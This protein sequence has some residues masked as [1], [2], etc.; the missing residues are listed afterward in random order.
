MLAS[1]VTLMNRETI[2]DF[3]PT[4]H[5]IDTSKG[6]VMLE[7]GASWC[8]YCQSAQTFILSTLV[9]YPQIRH[10]KIEDAKGLKLGRTY[11]VKLWPTLIFIK[12]GIELMRII[13]PIDSRPVADALAQLAGSGNQDKAI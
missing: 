3:V 1:G 7:F 4:R 11:A 2:T 8:G 10:I 12:D 13:R 5:E 9:H 6:P